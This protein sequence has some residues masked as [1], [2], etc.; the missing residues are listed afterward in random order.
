[1]AMVIISAT[2]RSV[3]RTVNCI[4]TPSDS[5]NLHRTRTSAPPRNTP[6][7]IEL[8]TNK[9]LEI[10][11]LSRKRNFYSIHSPQLG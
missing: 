8:K 7:K 9:S 11:P 10:F 3:E 4:W 5:A 6:E 1:M 2:D